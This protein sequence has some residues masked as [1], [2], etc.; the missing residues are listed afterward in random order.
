MMTIEVPNKDTN[1]GCGTICPK[2]VAQK[3]YK[4]KVGS[5]IDF[6]GA[7][8]KVV[9]VRITEETIFIDLEEAK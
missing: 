2:E 5:T 1:L 8:M 6:C 7:K 3:A 4:D 9:D